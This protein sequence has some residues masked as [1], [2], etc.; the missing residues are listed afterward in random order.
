M[1]D[2]RAR[3]W[4]A[5]EEEL[6]RCLERRDLAGAETLVEHLGALLAELEA[7]PPAEA[8][9]APAWAAVRALHDANVSRLRAWQADV[10]QEMARTAAARQALPAAPGAAR[11]LDRSG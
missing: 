1:A 3:R 7:D 6:A 5:A 2:D 4:Q 9:E 11:W 8:A 10:A